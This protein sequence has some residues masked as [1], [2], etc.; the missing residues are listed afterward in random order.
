MF[1]ELRNKIERKNKE[2]A[3]KNKEISEI[4]KQLQQISNDA[5]GIKKNF[6]KRKDNVDG[7]K[8]IIKKQEDDIEFLNRQVDTKDQLIRHLT[9]VVEKKNDEILLLNKK[10][11][12]GFEKDKPS[13]KNDTGNVSVMR[14]KTGQMNLSNDIDWVTQDLMNEKSVKLSEDERMFRL[15]NMIY[16]EDV[17]DIELVKKELGVSDSELK[18]LVNSMVSKGFLRFTDENEAEITPTGINYVTSH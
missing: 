18:N 12:S 11:D 3:L 13:L 10:A 17:S 16:P 4:K 2:L 15:L 7:L 5:I 1:K 8:K 6:D 9:S 14:S